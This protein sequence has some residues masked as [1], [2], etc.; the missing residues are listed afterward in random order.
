MSSRVKLEPN[1]RRL[2]YRSRDINV[3]QTKL[4]ACTHGFYKILAGSDNWGEG[5]G[6]VQDE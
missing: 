6:D 4:C 3:T 1:N 5:V 2:R